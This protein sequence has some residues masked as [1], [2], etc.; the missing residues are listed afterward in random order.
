MKRIFKAAIILCSAVLVLSGCKNNNSEAEEEV[1]EITS[2]TAD[3]ELGYVFKHYN[4]VRLA[5]FKSALTKIENPELQKHM[6]QVA[7]TYESVLKKAEYI[8]EDQQLEIEDQ[9]KNKY[10]VLKEVEVQ[11][12]AIEKIEKA[13]FDLNFVALEVKMTKRSLDL[14]KQKLIPNAEN[15]EL[16]YLFEASGELYEKNLREF[17]EWRRELQD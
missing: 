12:D 13:D 17:E 8:T 10:A 2:E 15:E 14:I 9:V 11:T 16:R 6:E 5:Q 7:K 3:A 4:K 1:V